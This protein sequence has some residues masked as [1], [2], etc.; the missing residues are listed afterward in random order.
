MLDAFQLAGPSVP[1]RA[2][3]RFPEPAQQPDSALRRRSLQPRRRAGERRIVAASMMRSRRAV[4]ALFGRL[5]GSPATASLNDLCSR[6]CNS[7]ACLHSGSMARS[8]PRKKSDPFSGNDPRL[9][10]EQ[11]SADRVFPIRAVNRQLRNVVPARGG[12]PLGLR[13][14]HAAQ[15]A[16]KVGSLP[17]LAVE[18]LAEGRS[19]MRSGSRRP[20]ISFPHGTGLPG[21]GNQAV[22]PANRPARLPLHPG[23]RP[24]NRLPRAH[25]DAR[26][27]SG[28]DLRN[29]RCHACETADLTS[30]P[31]GDSWIRVTKSRLSRQHQRARAKDRRREME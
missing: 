21:S 20:W 30:F 7:R 22:S 29:L 18:R 23:Q 4:A 24:G 1:P 9:R 19:A 11:P 28:F 27:L 15:S 12:P 8:G 3:T 17:R 10:P 13:R 5:S 14:S 31:E 2:R 25:A 26:A 16:L 6:S